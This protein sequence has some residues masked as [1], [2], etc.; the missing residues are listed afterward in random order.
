MICECRLSLK[1][2][3]D[4]DSRRSRSR[5]LLSN[6]RVVAENAVNF[7]HSGVQLQRCINPVVMFV[8]DDC[9]ERQWLHMR[10]SISI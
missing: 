6:G 9:V 4:C 1:W 3:Y 10:E 7:E 5:Q 2:Y 8:L